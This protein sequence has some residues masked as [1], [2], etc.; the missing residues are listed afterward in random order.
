MIVPDF[1]TATVEFPLWV[2]LL[3]I[4]FSPAVNVAGRRTWD[5]LVRRK[6]ADPRPPT[7]NPH[8]RLKYNLDR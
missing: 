8:D 3:I 5:A 2:V 6:N 1:L 4:A 7:G